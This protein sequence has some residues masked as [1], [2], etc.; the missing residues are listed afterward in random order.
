MPYILTDKIGIEQNIKQESRGLSTLLSG[1]FGKLFSLGWRKMSVKDNISFV[2]I[3]IIC[4]A[5]AE[6]ILPRESA[7]GIT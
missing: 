2:V 1:Q 7:S 5:V 6:K 4:V 3:L